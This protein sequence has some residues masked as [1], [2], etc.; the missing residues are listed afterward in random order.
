MYSPS[1]R[2]EVKGKGLNGGCGVAS[3]EISLEF[4]F[5]GPCVRV[6]ACVRSRTI[7]SGHLGKR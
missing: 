1:L 7:N 3:M 5:Y 4:Q 6:C 2:S